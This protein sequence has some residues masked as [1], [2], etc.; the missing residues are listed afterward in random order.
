MIAPELSPF[1]PAILPRF[2]MHC[3]NRHHNHHKTITII[4]ITITSCDSRPSP[5]ICFFQFRR[6]LRAMPF[7]SP[8][9]C[10]C[11][12]VQGQ[13]V[14]AGEQIQIQIEEKNNTNTT[15]YLFP[16]NSCRIGTRANTETYAGAFL[17]TR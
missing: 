6:Q 4:I 7:H 10:Q 2:Q 1:N 11:P 8:E 14:H 16:K 5:L 13:Q 17:L 9:T 15:N 3:R 12:S